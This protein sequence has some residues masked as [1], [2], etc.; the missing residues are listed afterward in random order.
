[1]SCHSKQ[2]A[3]TLDDIQSAAQRI[4]DHV[5][6]T[7]A[8]ASEV[9][10]RRLGCQVAFKA[11]NLQHVG[12]FKARGAVNAV[13]SLSDEDAHRGVVT[14]SSGNHAAALSRAA[15]LRGIPAFVVMP[16]NSSPIKIAAVRSYGVQPV[17]SGPSTQQ[18]EQAADELQRQSGATLIHPFETPAVMAGQG[19][20]ALEL[21]QQ[22]HQL[23]A[24]LV[25]VGGGGLLA[26]IL[27][28]IKSLRP[29]IEVYAVEPELADDTARSLS[30]G[31]PQPPTRYD[32]VADGLRT[33][34]GDHTFPIIRDLIDDLF[35]VSEDSILSA[36]RGIAE[37][38]HL[39]AEPSGAVAYAGLVE[40]AERFAGRCVAVVVSGGNLNFG[41]CSLGGQRRV[42]PKTS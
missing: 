19:T 20:V 6:R 34:V 7:P 41:D 24:V 30:A 5:A 31:S 4:A 29:E 1:M 14:H 9:I 10:S 2:H 8:I 18:R 38:A 36:M 23:D 33:G 17:F 15:K 25:P 21:L 13:M 27:V 40:N 22:L 37:D 12:A 3:I 11:E 28:A 16:E 35:L 26:G 32:T 42:T 39:V